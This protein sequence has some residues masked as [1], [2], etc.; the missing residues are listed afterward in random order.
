MEFSG[1]GVV[2]SEKILKI[3]ERGDPGP[4]SLKRFLRKKKVI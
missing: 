1:K 3:K 4:Y 2:T